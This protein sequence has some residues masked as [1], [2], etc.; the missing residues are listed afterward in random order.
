MHHFGGFT[1]APLLRRRTVLSA[2]PL[3][4]LVGCGGGASSPKSRGPGSPP[5]GGKDE[6]TRKIVYTAHIDVIVSQIELARDRVREI[7][8]GAGGYVAKSDFEQD[9]G[10]RRAATYTL[11]VP[12][13][14]LMG[15]LDTLGQLGTVVRNSTDSE[16]VTEEFYDLEARLKN[17]RAEEESLNRLLKENAGKLEDVLKIRTQI[18][19]NR[20]QIEK[21]EGRSKYLSKLSDLATIHLGIRERSGFVP[22]SAPSFAGRVGRAFED[23]LAA[24][25]EFGEFCVLAVATLLPWLF[26]L[27]ALLLGLRWALRR[28][29]ARRLARQHVGP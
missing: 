5:A 18:V 14:R 13:D 10:S 9:A 20:N 15:V 16:D 6:P 26:P 7:V 21:A 8:D 2:I 1:V 4:I 22:A 12:V 19:E 11:R 25:G 28:R 23:S 27:A 3:L 17:L 24:L 29:R